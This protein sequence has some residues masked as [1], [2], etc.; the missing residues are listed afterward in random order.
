MGTLVRVQVDA[1]D[2][3]AAKAAFRAAFDRIAQID[4]AL[5]DYKP[6]SEVNRLPASIG[7]DLLTVLT[8][9]QSLAEK[10]GGAFDVT[11]GPLTR[12]W[13]EARKA[14]RVPDAA[15]I[16]EARRHVGYRKLHLNPLKLDDP[17][18]HLDLGGIAKGYAADE[19]LDAISKLGISS[20][21]VA[22][23]GDLAFS[24]PPPGQTAWKIGVDVAFPRTLELVNGAVSTSGATEQHLD[25]GGK[26]YSHIID[27]ATGYGLTQDLR[28]TVIARRGIVADGL[29]TALSVLG[30]ERGLKLIE[31]ERDVTALIAVNEGG[32]T[33][34]YESAQVR[35]FVR[36]PSN[37][38]NH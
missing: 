11:I 14:G 31:K 6:D 10:T 12:L 23:S 37:G 35:R 28:V 24:N 30:V 4:A 16:E 38:G 26:R 22:V 36:K 9:A 15:A 29:S 2:A 3:A 17:D 5:S 1:P 13:R 8:A 20:A 34:V 33:R 21:L 18:M 19:A 27:P 7:P 25:A 32:R